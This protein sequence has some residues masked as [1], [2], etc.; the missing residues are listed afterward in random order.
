MTTETTARPEVVTDEY[1]EY[2]DDLR[3]SGIVN[4]FGA[5]PYLQEEFDLSKEDASV[6]LNYWM[7]TFGD[8]NR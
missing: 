8:P 5:R 7:K 4:M 2:L 1:L 3:E 6:V